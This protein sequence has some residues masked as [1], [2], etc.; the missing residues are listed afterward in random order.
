EVSLDLETDLRGAAGLDRG[1][2]LHGDLAVPVVEEERSSGLVRDP[3]DPEVSRLP[4]GDA[5]RDVERVDEPEAKDALLALFRGDRLVNRDG[6][7]LPGRGREGQVHVGQEEPG[8][9]RVA[10]VP[11]DRLVRKNRRVEEPG[12]PAGD[13]RM[14]LDEDLR[15]L[16]DGVED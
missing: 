10:A 6:G 9:D 3:P 7:V 11:S 5:D 16:D 8:Q 2:Q 15:T 14:K 12:A 13:A 4:A 1:Q